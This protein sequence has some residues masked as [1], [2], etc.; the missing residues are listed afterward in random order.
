[1]ATFTAQYP[2][3]T[4]TAPTYSAVTAT[5]K[6]HFVSDSSFLI[7]KNT[8]ASP[9]TVTVVVPGSKYG[10][11]IPDVPVTVPITTGERWIGPFK[12]DMCDTQ[13]DISITFSPTTSVT[14]ALVQM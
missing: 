7:V 8:S 1:M 5:D 4:G 14:A 11:A 9:C 3:I 12:S 13:G 10:Q 2:T 6:V